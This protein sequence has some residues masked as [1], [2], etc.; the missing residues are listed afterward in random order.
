[1]LSEDINECRKKL[2]EYI[3]VM[4]S[5]D[6]DETSIRHL[7][8]RLN[9][10]Y[11]HDFRHYY[12]DFLPL[13]H[14]VSQEDNAYSLDWLISNLEKARELVENDIIKGTNELSQLHKPLF[15]LSDHINLEAARYQYYS[16]NDQKLKD[17]EAS[18]KDLQRKLRESVGKLEET[19]H[20]ASSMQT[21]YM[22]ILG[23][24]AAVIL[25]FVGHFSFAFSALQNIHSVA[26][27]Q[28]IIVLLLSGLIFYNMLCVLMGF[29]KEINHLE[30]GWYTKTNW[31]FNG[32]MCMM[33]VILWICLYA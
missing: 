25:A 6:M 28:L 19:A 33:M 7:L 3:Y 23:I 20:R 9:T 16:S 5:S 15:K 26:L 2:R 24:F 18:N 21:Q 27:Y 1:M 10:L 30:I 13:I 8:L 31:W 12:S 11:S 32:L 14:T 4:A 22:T 17:M 29:L